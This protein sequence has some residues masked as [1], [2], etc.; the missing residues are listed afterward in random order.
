[1]TH[2]M[3]GVSNTAMGYIQNSKFEQEYKL[4]VDTENAKDSELVKAQKEAAQAQQA[5][6]SMKDKQSPEAQQA[7]ELLKQ[8]Q[9]EVQAVISGHSPAAQATS[10]VMNA[11]GNAASSIGDKI[12][13]LGKDTTTPSIPD[14]RVQVKAPDGTIGHIPQDQLKDAL[15]QGYSEI[16]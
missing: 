10:S 9:Q 5:Y 15:D 7:L 2:Y 3:A 14:G 6:D 11:I 13:N 8:R 16:K 12:N 4:K 1:M